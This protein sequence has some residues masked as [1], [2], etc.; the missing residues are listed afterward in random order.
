MGVAVQ[1]MFFVFGSAFCALSGS[2]ET[3]L[4][5]RLVMGVG[6]A[7]SVITFAMV[8]DLVDDTQERMR[9]QAFFS[10]MQPLMLLLAP[11]VGGVVVSVLNWR[12]LFWMLAAW[13]LLTAVLVAAFIPE[14]VRSSSASPCCGL[15]PFP[16]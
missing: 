12:W 14:S 13:G 9:L 4:L 11:S 16:G 1:M 5:A 3:L 6:Q 15:S 7:V 2:F 10:M 8:R